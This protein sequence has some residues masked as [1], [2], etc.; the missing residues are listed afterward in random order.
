MSVLRTAI[1]ALQGAFAEHRQMLAGL[2]VEV[3]ELRQ[4][5]D[6]E[7]SFSALI[8]PG[9]ESTVQ[10]KLLRDSEMFEPL[11]Q[12]IIN[13][14]P[15]MATCAGTVLLAEQLL[16]DPTRHFGTLPMVVKRNAYGRQSDSFYIH[17]TFAGIDDVPMP[18]IRAPEIVQ[19]GDGVEILSSYRNSPTAVRYRNMLALTWHPEIT[20]FPGIHRYFLENMVIKHTT[21]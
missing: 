12:K 1:L 13:G 11:R 3:I 15:V 21:A 10:G 9:G 2:G 20:G 19:C 8:L 18:F 16:D 5:K 17:G 6:L 7:Q 14:L 4:K